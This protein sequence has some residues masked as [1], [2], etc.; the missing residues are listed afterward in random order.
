VSVREAIR[1]VNS[2]YA[3][4]S[5][6]LFLANSLNLLRDPNQVNQRYESAWFSEYLLANL[7]APP[8]PEH[9]PKP[10]P[11]RNTPGSLKVTNSPSPQQ[12]PG[13]SRRVFAKSGP[14]RSLE[15]HGYSVEMSYRKDNGWRPNNELERRWAW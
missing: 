6:H 10:F 3:N 5:T 1:S 7:L 8:P 15:E 11:T 12:L 9:S 4:Y 2:D 13:E 14:L